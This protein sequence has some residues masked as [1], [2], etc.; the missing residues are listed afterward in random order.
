MGN[1]YMKMSV[2]QWWNYNDR[3]KPYYLDRNLSQ[4]HFVDHKSHMEFPRIETE[5]RSENP[6]TEHLSN[7]MEQSEGNNRCAL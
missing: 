6:A 4:L 1:M 5:I 3:N 2:E 7:G